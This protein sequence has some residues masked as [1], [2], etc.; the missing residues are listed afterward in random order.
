MIVLHI[1]ILL[2]VHEYFEKVAH[3]RRAIAYHRPVFFL[4][5]YNTFILY[6][7]MLRRTW[8]GWTCSRFIEINNRRRWNPAD[9]KSRA[10]SSSAAAKLRNRFE[11]L[12]TTRRHRRSASLRP[13][14]YLFPFPPPPSP[15]FAFFSDE[16]ARGGR[17]SYVRHSVHVQRST[18]ADD[19]HQTAGRGSVARLPGGR[20]QFSGINSR[21]RFWPP[22]GGGLAGRHGIALRR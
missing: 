10:C 1:V 13:R 7:D 16:F 9:R 11:T 17:R 8:K 22:A 21:L 6:H 2:L 12:A 14:G 4:F 19:Q 18:S 3:S 15:F 5:F 20:L